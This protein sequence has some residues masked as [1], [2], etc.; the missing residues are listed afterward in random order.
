MGMNTSYIA[1]SAATSARPTPLPDLDLGDDLR[2]R[3]LDAADAALLVEATSGEPGRSL[4]GPH[5]GPYSPGDAQA[6]LA[7]WDPAKGGQFGLGIVRHGRLLGAVGLI[8]DGPG[9]IELA[10][11]LRPEERGRGIA[12]RA[13]LAATE[14]AHDAL[15]APR[16]WLEIEPGNEPSQRLAQRVG[17]QF[18]QHIPRHC[19]TW[20]H[21]DADHDTWHDCLIWT[22]D[23]TRPATT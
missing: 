13:A 17:F 22:H 4:W 16:I 9:S 2:L 8:P 1:S 23:S 14:W 10:Y 6:A 18:E 21:P 19:R 5:L 12:S 20:T 11:W 7:D 3:A 15:A